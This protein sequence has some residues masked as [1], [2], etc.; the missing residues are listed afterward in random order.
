MLTNWI[1]YSLNISRNIS[2]VSYHRR[3]HIIMIVIVVVICSPFGAT[4]T[5]V[6]HNF[7]LINVGTTV[8]KSFIPENRNMRKC[9]MLHALVPCN[10][11][12]TCPW[13]GL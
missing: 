7:S 12:W 9:V 1:S 5:Y 3:R 13:Q 11:C 2:I 8:S 4:W 6:M 10:C